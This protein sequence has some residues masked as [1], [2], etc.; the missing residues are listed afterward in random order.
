MK[1]S[2]FG[3]SVVL[4]LACLNPGPAPADDCV[5]LV[6]KQ[7]CGVNTCE[8]VDCEWETNG[9]CNCEIKQRVFPG[10]GFGQRICTTSGESCATST[11][12]DGGGGPVPQGAARSSQ[13]AVELPVGVQQALPHLQI[14]LDAFSTRLAQPGDHEV[15]GLVSLGEILGEET[16][17]EPAREFRAAV[18]VDGHRLSLEV[19]I[20]ADSIQGWIMPDASE[21]HL[22]FEVAGS[23][24]AVAWDPQSQPRV[25]KLR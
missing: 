2:W 4:L 17:W 16:A 10:G 13:A 18:T 11:C 14:I 3:F 5:G 21:G 23:L 25:E 7:V 22:D 24:Q 1:S 8:P 9:F 12:S 20:G 6:C 19:E 15:Q